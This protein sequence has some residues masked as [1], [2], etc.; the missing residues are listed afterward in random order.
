MIENSDNNINTNLTIDNNNPNNIK[1]INE[2][3]NQTKQS[4]NYSTDELKESIIKIIKDSGIEPDLIK[5]QDKETLA[6]IIIK[7]DKYERIVPII[8]AY[9][10]LLGITDAFFDWLLCENRD[11][12]TSLDI[13]AQ[14]GNK[15]VI[16]YMY[17]IISKTTESKFRISEKRKGIFHYAAMNN[18]C[19]PIIY[20]NEKLQKFFKNITIIDVPSEYG[21]TPLLAAC[22]K[23]SKNAVDLLLDL[24][25]NINAVDNEGNNCL[26]YAVEGNNINLLKKLL[27]RGAD[28]TI[29][30]KEN[31][32][33]ID[34][35]I[36]KNNHE[37]VDILSAK[38]SIF[39]NPCKT[40]HE[41]TGLRSS[42]NNIT[43]FVIILFMGVGK[44][45]YLSRMYYIYEGNF[46]SDV[47]PF[48]YEIETIKELCYKGNDKNYTNCKIDEKLVENYVNK[49]GIIRPTID[50]ITDLFNN[51][52]F[53]DLEAIY[54]V[55]WGFSS[56]EIIMLFFIL[57]F[58]CFS[59][60]IFVKKKT[61]KKQPSLIKLF[62]SYRN[63][64]VKCRTEKKD[65]TVHCIVCNGCVKDFDHHCS[66]LNICISKENLGWFR[67]F[68]YFFL[69]YILSN[70]VFFSYSK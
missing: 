31:Q 47:I 45:I 44:W 18:Q 26:H 21:I 42:H 17:T 10:S 6:H 66:W 40:N 24:G 50:K 33:P 2:V 9:M 25:A 39:Q 64:C 62:E 1:V 70:F 56:L 60:H 8:E 22:I 63:I 59:S 15:E 54:K 34:L 43:L 4:K 52:T 46:K 55:A 51:S 19:F 20:F 13:C 30:N 3:I 68:L 49:T 69:I 35:A 11:K 16:K 36:R 12:Q 48:V 14:N 29:R 61:Y 65:S 5:N 28:K 41:I 57:K 27:V 67:G 58:M 53:G 7:E 38:A 37:I 32:L 23:G